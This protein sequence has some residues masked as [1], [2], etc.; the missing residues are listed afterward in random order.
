MNNIYFTYFQEKH[1]NA[2][3]QIVIM[4]SQCLYCHVIPG[5]CPFQFVTLITK[6]F[7]RNVDHISFQQ[8]KQLRLEAVKI[9]LSDEWSSISKTF[10]DILT[11]IFNIF[12][13]QNVHTAVVI[14][15]VSII[16]TG[17][18]AGKTCH[19]LKGFETYN[20]SFLISH[21]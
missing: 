14:N 20:M 4:I 9:L 18:L 8:N 21:F 6:T 5:V 10:T 2:S 13:Q 1:S 12:Y 16:K 11:S 7:Y 17:Q 3:Q 19:V 15:V